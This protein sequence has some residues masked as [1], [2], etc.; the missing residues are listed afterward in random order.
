MSLTSLTRLTNLKNPVPGDTSERVSASFCYRLSHIL[1]SGG[2][3]SR[4]SVGRWAATSPRDKT[5]GAY[6]SGQIT[7]RDYR[8]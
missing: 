6:L 4:R 2:V 1:E 7:L 5:E 8:A 3:S